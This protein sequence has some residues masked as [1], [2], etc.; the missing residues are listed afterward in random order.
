MPDGVGWAAWE[1]LFLFVSKA[2]DTRISRRQKN[3]KGTVHSQTHLLTLRRHGS[4]LG[5]LQGY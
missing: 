5:K 3:H 2:L 1:G 4:S